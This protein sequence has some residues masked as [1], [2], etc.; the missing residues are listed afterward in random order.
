MSYKIFI[1]YLNQ[2][3][4]ITSK[5][6]IRFYAMKVKNN[7]DMSFYVLDVKVFSLYFLR[8]FHVCFVWYLIGGADPYYFGD[9]NMRCL[10]NN[11][12]KGKRSVPSRG[13]WELTHR[14]IYYKGYYFEFLGECTYGKFLNLLIALKN[15]I[16]AQYCFVKKVNCNKKYQHNVWDIIDDAAIAKKSDQTTSTIT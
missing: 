14:V 15:V 8:I 6:R 1:D 10:G 2:I 13:V 16:D 12:Y 9:T 3:I 5:E 4:F 7:V 11:K